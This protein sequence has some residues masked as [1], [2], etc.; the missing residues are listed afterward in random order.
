MAAAANAAIERA[1]RI[2]GGAADPASRSPVA[3]RRCPARSIHEVDN[4]EKLRFFGLMREC[5]LHEA[6]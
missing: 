2:A 4:E 3:N 1:T 5:G 6:G